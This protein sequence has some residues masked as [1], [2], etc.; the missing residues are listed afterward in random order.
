[1]KIIQNK[2]KVVTAALAATSLLF[3]TSYAGT[4]NDSKQ[5]NQIISALSSQEYT[6]IKL[7]FQSDPSLPME[8]NNQAENEQAKQLANK[9]YNA[10]SKSSIL[11]NLSSI[12]NS[13]IPAAGNKEN[14]QALSSY[15][16]D[17]PALDTPYI[18]E[19]GP[20]QD[21]LTGI[22][23]KPT[24]DGSSTIDY[25][26]ILMPATSKMQTQS[27]NFGYVFSAS[28][29]TTNYSLFAKNYLNFLTQPYNFKKS[30]TSGIPFN[31]LKLKIKNAQNDHKISESQQA[32]TALA[33]IMNSPSFRSYQLSIRHLLA[34]RSMATSNLT[35][36]ISER[37]PVKVSE[38]G[39]S[40][41]KTISPLAI[42]KT[43]Q[44][45][46]ITDPNWYNNLQASSPASLQRK[47]LVILAEIEAQ[48]YQAHI[49]RER[50]IALESTQLLMQSNQGNTAL[51]KTKNNLTNTIKSAL[52]EGKTDK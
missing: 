23:S 33:Q 31:K 1:M 27:M 20:N 16:T 34:I 43:T 39:S 48:N 26:T 44:T 32:G 38:E 28:D 25:H 40:T 18:K 11:N 22:M 7:K 29:T 21:L 45:Q 4:N 46:R 14:Q 17:I 41:T 52:S 51:M 35:Q 19:N 5:L 3:C 24:S 42:E 50:L 15:T 6:N 2:R 9:Q 37:T 49:D 30:L 10:D 36:L 13:I 12:R 8:L 47:T